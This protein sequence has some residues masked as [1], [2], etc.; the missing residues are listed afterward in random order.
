MSVDL[1]TFVV[2]M[3]AMGEHINGQS[4]VAQKIFDTIRQRVR[5]VRDIDNVEVLQYPLNTLALGYGDC[6]DF[7]ILL[8]ACFKCV[9]FPV[10]IVTIDTD[11]DGIYNHIFLSVETNEGIMYADATNSVQPFGWSYD[12]YT[13]RNVLIV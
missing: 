2:N 4:R 1:R 12:K 5:Y 9:G 6:D 8:G 11:Q 7:V 3:F 13:I 10:A